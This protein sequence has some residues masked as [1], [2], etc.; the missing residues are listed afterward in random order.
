VT[1][2]PGEPPDRSADVPET[3]DDSDSDTGSEAGTP[4]RREHGSEEEI[5]EA[6]DE[7][8]PASDAPQWWSGESDDDN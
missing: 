2:T 6:G 7:S 8:F 1:D 5:D 4:G 3:A